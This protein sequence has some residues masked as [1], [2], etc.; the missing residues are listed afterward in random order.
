MGFI[1]SAL[2]VSFVVLAGKAVKEPILLICTMPEC[3]TTVGC[4]C[5]RAL[6]PGERVTHPKV[7]RVE[8][9]EDD[10]GR[11]YT[12]WGGSGT[13]VSLSWQDDGRTLKVFIRG[14]RK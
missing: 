14:K 2:W 10:A 6:L 3:Q 9:I 4:K 1:R 13:G 8:V 5:G 11:A 12:F 7:N